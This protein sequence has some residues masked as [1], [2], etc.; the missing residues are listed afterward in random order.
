MQAI[1]TSKFYLKGTLQEK[2]KVVELSQEEFK[3][4]A[5]KGC[6]AVAP[7]GSKS[8]AKRVAIQKKEKPYQDTEVKKAPKDRMMRPRRKRK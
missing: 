1:V 6:V 8:E 5:E 7:A 2:G 3:R 4:I